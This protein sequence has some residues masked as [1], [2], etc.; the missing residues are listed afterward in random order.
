MINCKYNLSCP[1]NISLEAT[2]AVDGDTFTLVN[3]T[4]ISA[5]IMQSLRF[6]IKS[7]APWFNTRKITL[8]FCEGNEKISNSVL[9]QEGS[10]GFNSDNTSTYQIISIP[11]RIFS[12]RSL[13]FDTLEIQVSGGN[14]P[15]GFFI[16]DIIIQNGITVSSIKPDLVSLL[17]AGTGGVSVFGRSVENRVEIKTINAGSSKITI[18]DDTNVQGQS[19]YYRTSTDTIHIPREFIGCL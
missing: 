11:Q 19:P 1:G 3:T 9:I 18:T 14:T 12:F 4:T 17:S 8:T 16:D 7:K 6:K 2:N 5:V 10:Y 15:I 13:D